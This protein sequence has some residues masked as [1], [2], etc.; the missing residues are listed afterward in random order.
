M[1][2]SDYNDYNTADEFEGPSSSSVMNN[3]LSYLPP[4]TSSNYS[5]RRP[6]RK[7]AGR[8]AGSLRGIRSIDSIDFS[9][10][11]STSA[12]AQVQPRRPPN[13]RPMAY[14]PAQARTYPSHLVS[15]LASVIAMNNEAKLQ[16]SE[17]RAQ[18]S[19]QIHEDYQERLIDA[20]VQDQRFLKSEQ[21]FYDRID[22]VTRQR[23]V[24][25]R[26]QGDYMS[27]RDRYR[28]Q[29]TSLRE[30]LASQQQVLADYR[31]M[32]V[33][34]RENVHSQVAARVSRKYHQI[35]HQF[36]VESAQEQRRLKAASRDRQRIHKEQARQVRAQ[37]ATYFRKLSS[38]SQQARRL[39]E[40]ISLGQ[41]VIRRLQLQAQD[42]QDV[43]N[44]LVGRYNTLYTFYQQQGW[45]QLQRQLPRLKKKLDAATLQAIQLKS[46][47]KMNK[48]QTAAASSSESRV[49][50]V[51]KAGNRRRK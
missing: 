36:M 8:P 51:P 10:S 33:L 30:Q 25:E 12:P 49:V 31:M 29:C 3:I 15:H 17:L 21:A 13:S 32:A 18:L 41:R 42:D 14:D 16:Q 2:D 50:P 27:Q 5:V 46:Q 22:A 45:A 43:Y 24:A 35:R 47:L 20:E 7:T 34:D 19:R 40:N 23:D 48:R 26:L 4:S 1:E 44:E 28:D 38:A 37:A 9:A 11:S 39:Q 6:P